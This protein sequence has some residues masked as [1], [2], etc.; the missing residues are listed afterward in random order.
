M[1]GHQIDR[2]ECVDP[3]AAFHGTMAKLQGAFDQACADVNARELALKTALGK[4][5]ATLGEGLG[6]STLQDE[7]PLTRFLTDF[8]S[9]LGA[10]VQGWLD[11]VGKYERNSAF[12][13]D[14]ADSLVIFVL[15]K[16]KAGK[17]S[18]GNYVAYGS[19]DPD[20]ATRTAARVQFFTAAT[21]DNQPG[22]DGSLGVGGFFQTGVRETTSSIQGFRMPGLT[23][24]D[25]PGLHSA[26]HENGA[27]ASDYVDVA[28]LVI[29]PMHT[30]SPGRS[31]DVTEICELLRGRKRLL[32]V[33]TQCDRHEEDE[34]PDG[35]LI[36][37]C[38]MKDESVR[39][40]QIDY[41]RRALQAA[42]SDAE[43]D[44]LS[45]SVRHAQ[46]HG[47][48][49]MVLEESG[50][51]DFFRLLARMAQSEGVNRK[52]EAPSRN[53]DSFVEMLLSTDRERD[54]LSVENVRVALKALDGRLAGAKAELDLGAAQAKA[55]V[56]S[57]IGPAVADRVGCY[58]DHKDQDGFEQ[59]C[60]AALGQ[61]VAEETRRAV[62]PLFTVR[63]TMLPI[64]DFSRLAGFKTLE[65]NTIRIPRSNRGVFGALGGSAGAIGGS[66]AGAEIG[67][68]LGS[69]IPVAGTAVGG[70]VGG[71]IGSLLGGAGGN[72]AGRAL[73]SDWEETMKSGDNR[74]EVQISALKLLQAAG[75]EAIDAFFTKIEAAMIKPVRRRAEG[76][77]TQLE[78]FRSTLA[79]EVHSNG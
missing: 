34:G 62:L 6:R 74:A 45:I 8:N 49:P 17:S 4:A 76:V 41:V 52:R 28:D 11:Q 16:V 65:A 43:I 55:A 64:A 26:T 69:V 14:Y 73:G 23:W 30:G 44:V 67:A 10:L 7:H 61:I 71:L 70:V 66:L 77:L 13:S 19:S 53:L 51:A 21:A 31:G 63:G 22:N 42:G 38:I 60:T 58:A 2:H 75:V 54:P 3:R 36:Q 39:Q 1:S 40:G 25:S 27:L 24:V 29:Y 50:L 9:E 15:G 48:D 32:A 56:L 35:S 59:A 57:R 78:E 46:S 79:R 12:R 47:N 18:L 5:A 68:L 37:R 20:P 33:I 72:A